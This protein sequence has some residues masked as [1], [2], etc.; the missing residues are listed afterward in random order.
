MPSL[1]TSQD[2]WESAYREERQLRETL[3]K[4][5]EELKFRLENRE[6]IIQS[7]ICNYD[8]NIVTERETESNNV[9]N[10]NHE[11]SIEIKNQFIIP[12]DE[13]M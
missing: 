3:Q 10:S 1:L 5:V 8:N 4:Q 13:K 9:T 11:I 7:N 6:N 12:N 2:M